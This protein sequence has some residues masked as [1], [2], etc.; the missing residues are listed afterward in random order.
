MSNQHSSEGHHSGNNQNHPYSNCQDRNSSYAQTQ[1][2]H[3]SPSNA[4]PYSNYQDQNFSYGQTQGH[5]M[6][7]SN[8]YSNSGVEYGGENAFYNNTLNQQYGNSN[9]APDTPS[10]LAYNQSTAYSGGQNE[11][12]NAHQPY[13]IAPTT[14]TSFFNNDNS[15]N[16][17][18]TQG[19]VN[20]QGGEL[21]SPE[22]NHQGL[23]ASTW[24]D[25]RIP[26]HTQTFNG[27]NPIQTP[28][29]YVQPGSMVDIA[30]YSGRLNTPEKLAEI[31]A[32][33]SQFTAPNFGVN[34]ADARKGPTLP[35]VRCRRKDCQ[36][37]L[38]PDTPY[39]ACEEH[40]GFYT[41]WDPSYCWKE[42][43]SEKFLTSC[44]KYFVNGQCTGK[45]VLTN[46]GR[47]GPLCTTHT[48]QRY[49]SSK[50]NGEWYEGRCEGFIDL[51]S[52]YSTLIKQEQS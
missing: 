28:L 45:R 38:R 4:H 11:L 26:P 32:L 16:R 52:G 37:M 43:M 48:K 19:D 41:D 24:H 5:H 33:G 21:Q 3:M 51:P 17:M 2:H 8:A 7:P 1:E 42:L 31:N 47:L 20:H 22:R 15:S 39:L 9:I 13:P 23:T 10:L 49:I 27:Y 35:D 30:L 34:A 46:N 14:P 12:D 44:F 50:M 25:P 29:N 40:R 36:T 18:Q 6:S